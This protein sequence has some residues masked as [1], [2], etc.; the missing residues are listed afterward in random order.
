[1]EDIGVQMQYELYHQLKEQNQLA[2]VLDAKELLKNP[3]IALQK[4]CYNLDIPFHSEML[5]WEMGSRKKT[6]VGLNIGTVM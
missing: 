6:V 3:K 1:M 4:L 5:N 2:A